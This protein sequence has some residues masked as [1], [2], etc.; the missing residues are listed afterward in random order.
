[1]AHVSQSQCQ[2]FIL[3]SMDFCFV[4]SSK[5]ELGGVMKT[6]PVHGA[7]SILLKNQH[8]SECMSFTESYEICRISS[9]LFAGC[10][11]IVSRAARI[12]CISF[13]YSSMRFS[14]LVNITFLIQIIFSF[15]ACVHFSKII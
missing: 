15:V 12:L 9:T 14:L 10:F 5:Y 1:M 4:S 13:V 3:L 7:D 6:R 11:V 8:I 2:M